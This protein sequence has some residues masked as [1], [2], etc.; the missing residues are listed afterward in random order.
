M[1]YI[2]LSR[3]EVFW[4]SFSTEYREFEIVFGFRLLNYAGQPTHNKLTS[5]ML[6]LESKQLQGS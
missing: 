2:D 6:I 1:E 5:I 3:K 4:K